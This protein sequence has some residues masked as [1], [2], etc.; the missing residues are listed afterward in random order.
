MQD[1]ILL[2][3]AGKGIGEAIALDFS[4]KS[5]K[6]PSFNPVLILCSR[7]YNDIAKLA[8]KCRALGTQAVP[9]EADI[10]D[11][12]DIDHLIEQT[13]EEFGTI[14]CL[15]NNAGVGRFKDLKEMTEDDFDYIMSVNMK[16]TF[17]L[18]QKVFSIMEKRRS[19]HI[20]FITSVAAEMAF[21][22][23]S[24]YSMSKF[25]QKG[26]VE[27]LRLYGRE[28]NVKITNV[29]PGAVYTPMWGEAAEELKPFMMMPEDI[30]GPVVDAYL[31]PS[32]T[33]VEE[34]VL[35]PVG[36]DINS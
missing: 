5:Q 19:G 14:D 36:G 12:D 32:R 17:F 13:T 25:G 22:S 9:I 28:C 26:L 34:I 11:L 15:I 7:T 29:M 3:G 31:Q 23:S 2:T 24:V 27:A 8:E 35:R 30:A 20:F 16:G 10:A 18:T 6:N 1:I 21:K 33:S 4:Q